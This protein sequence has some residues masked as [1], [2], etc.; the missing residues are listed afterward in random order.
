MIALDGISH[1]YGRTAVLRNLT[2]AMPDNAFV[3]LLGPSGCGKT[4][5][6][7]L[8][9]GFIR[10]ES[11]SLSVGGIIYTDARTFVAPEKRDMGMVFQ[12][13]AVWPHMTVFENI[14][15]GL[16]LRKLRRD[17]VRTRVEQALDLVRLSALGSRYPA[18]LSGG[19]QQRVAIARAIVVRP[20]I[21]LLDEP[22]SSLDTRLRQSMLG[23]LKDL[24]RE[25]GIG[26]VYVTHDQSEAMMASDEV[27]VMNGGVVE[28]Q[29]PP[30]TLYES[31]ATRF[32]AEFLGDS[33]I[34]QGRC[35][36]IDGEYAMVS[37]GEGVALRCRARNVAAGSRV[38]V[39]IRPDAG[40]LIEQVDGHANAAA[41][42]L[43][44]TRFGGTFQEIRLALG[45]ANISLLVSSSISLN[46][47]SVPLAFDADRC[48]A[49]PG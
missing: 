24:Q 42:R 18:Q 39:C 5:L 40:R 41:A 29:G 1:S 30:R 3:S 21:L 6:L 26:F 45:G 37:L 31:P 33:S 49:F 8:L 34:V 12:T 9:A 47:P 32:V 28:Q 7:R 13:F 11:G 48:M 20:R 46:G 25:L 2:I 19:Q 44:E 35:S 16:R 10:P 15:F 4:T 14:A 27:I 38:S 43:L 22:L 36:S 17:E 23:E